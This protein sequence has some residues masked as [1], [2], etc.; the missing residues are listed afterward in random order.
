MAK[1]LSDLVPKKVKQKVTKIFATIHGDHYTDDQLK[2]IDDA[3]ER[4]EEEDLEK[5]K[6]PTKE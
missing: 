3:L 6:L 1:K 5:R 4:M 2:E